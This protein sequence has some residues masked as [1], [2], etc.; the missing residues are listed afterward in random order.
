MAARKIA[1]GGQTVTKR[2]DN[3]AARPAISKRLLECFD[4]VVVGFQDQR[5]RSDDTMDYWDAYNSILSNRQFYNGE[6]R[7]FVPIINNAVEARVTRFTNQIFPQAG[8]FVDVTTTEEKVP[9]ATMALLEG[10]VRR[11]RL[12]TQVIP[13][14]IRCGDVEGQY[15][16]YLD[17][18]E[19]VRTVTSRVTKPATMDVDG[20]EVEDPTEDDIDDVEETQVKDAHP[21]VEVINDSD[22]L[23]LPVTVDSI[24]EAIDCGGSVTLLRRWSKSTLRRL[25]REGAIDSAAGEAMIASMSRMLRQPNDDV[26]KRGAQAAGIRVDDGNVLCQ[27]YETWTELK[28]DGDYRLCR[29]YYGGDQQILGC[30]LCPYWC[31]KVPILSV[32]VK[33]IA[34]VA[35][36]KSLIDPCMD[37][38]IFANDAVNEGADTAHFS[39]MP[40]TMTDP[41]KNPKIGSMILG[42]A[43]VWE[44]SPKDTQFA[45]FPNLWQTAFER[46]NAAE[47]K[48]FQTLGVNPAMITQGS[49]NGDKKNQAEVAQEQQVDLLTTADAVT[50][51]EEGILTPLLQRFAEYDAQFRNSKTTIRVYGE[52]GLRAQMEEVEP[53]QMGNRFEFR[54]LGVEAARNAAQVQQ[55][56]AFANV[57]KGIPPQMYEGYRLNMAPMLVQAATNVFGPRLGPLTFVDTRSTLSVNPDTE[58][59]MLVHG[60][61]VEVHPLDNDAEHLAAHAQ[62]AEGGMPNSNVAA[63]ITAHQKQI[64][65]KTMAQA[66][67]TPG[68]QPPP[69]PP[70]AGGPGPLPGSQP[71]APAGPNGPP[72]MIHR[73]QLPAAGAIGM[74]EEGRM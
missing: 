67:N 68:M 56:I 18:K 45:A 34:G 6:S 74:P 48:V 50:V 30:T 24:E 8:R 49:G 28:V 61:T 13:A 40:I 47:A 22:L 63:H 16:L 58:N 12:R 55:Q 2:T 51:I 46:V 36:G 14:M 21:T 69:G 27:V 60:F 57:L 54:W 25:I 44:T 41:E 72:G 17:W 42:L 35:K 23:I 3:I 32:P 20:E 73:D 65:M 59:D 10:Y 71:M 7:I 66:Q 15:S 52:M 19:K 43:A 33:K 5:E 26:R 38:Q 64:Q 70:G 9:N 62:L 4:D 39:A 37:M 53:I 11:A 31:D 29:A 1:R